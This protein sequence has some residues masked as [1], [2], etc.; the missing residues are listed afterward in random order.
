[1]AVTSSLRSALLLLLCALPLGGAAQSFDREHTRFGF[2]LRTRWGNA[3]EGRFPQYEGEV[4]TLPDGRHQVRIRLATAALEVEGPERYTRFA[5]GER[6]FDA[7]RHPWVEFLSDP[8]P[9]ALLQSG[10]R[11]RGTLSMHG[12]SRYENF[13]LMPQACARPARACDVVARGSVSRADYGLDGW[14]F[15]LVDRVQFTLRVR[16]QDAPP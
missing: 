9:A 10:G 6:F 8:Y 3:I 7:P 16:L 13:V 5:R 4:T 11:L 15:V 2:E 1:V 14:R 12:I